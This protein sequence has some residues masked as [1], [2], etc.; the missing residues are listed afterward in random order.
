MQT[1]SAAWL[2][3][4]YRSA[5]P[6]AEALRIALGSGPDP[7][8]FPPSVLEAE[9]RDHDALV[10]LGV[11]V[12][13][14]ADPEYPKRLRAA[15]GPLV[16][17]VAGRVSLLEDEGVPV[18][19]GYRGAA[20]QQLAELLD[21]GG[22]AIVVLSKGLLKAKSLLRALHEPLADG[23]IALVTAEPPRASWGP[24]RDR[25]RD[26]LAARLTR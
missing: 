9:Q 6:T 11:R 10:E 22:R 18:L 20:G 8:A 17:Q 21:S 16:L 26:A 15:D 25:N 5:L 13:P 2:A 7:S 23:A 19:R 1:E 14:I 24:L 4:A 3:L 12:L